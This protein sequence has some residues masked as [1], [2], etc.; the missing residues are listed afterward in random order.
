MIITLYNEDET[1][2]FSNRA[3]LMYISGLGNIRTDKYSLDKRE[4]EIGS[5]IFKIREATLEDVAESIERAPQI[6]LPKDVLF[7]GYKMNM[8][9]IDELLEIGGGTGGFAVMASL[10][11]GV[12][13][14]SYEINPAVH[15]I[16]RKNIRR[17]ELEDRIKAIN[18]DGFAAP[19]S[20]FRNV[21][22]DNPEPWRFLDGRMERIENVGT[23]L[24]T[25]SQAEFFSRFM[26]ENNFQ[27]SIHELI[28]IPIKIS[29]M[30][31]RP[32][33]NILYHTGFIVTAR[34][35]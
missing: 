1:F 32:E 33:S 21:F 11:F 4:I 5:R 19:V 23:I 29:E 35:W 28:D 30:G 15:R 16:M 13:I 10:I 8:S 9:R 25:Y 12:R 20:E 7:I 24:P 3:G 17:F 22:I 31:I 26:R 2:S 14:T 27:V 18:E 6:I 34:R